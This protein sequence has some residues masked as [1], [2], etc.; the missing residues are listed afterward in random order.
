ML[1]AA[2]IGCGRMGAL[3]TE[4]TRKSVPSIWLPLS[5]T[6]A[7]ASLP[8]Y[9]LVAVC[10][11]A[12]EQAARV[13][14]KFPGSRPY[15]DHRLMLEKEKPAVVGIATRTAG[16]CDIIADCVRAGV[17]GVHA[18]KPLAGSL[19]ECRM[20]LSELE[21]KGVAFT[22][23]AVRRYMA[24]YRLAREVMLSGEIGQLR[25]VVIEHG[26]DMLMWGHPHSVDL[27][28]FYRPDAVA[29]G[30]RARLDIR[31]GAYSDGV[32]DDDPL[33][34][35]ACIDFSDGS[36]AVVTSGHGFNVR[37]FGETGS[38]TVVGDGSRVELRKKE[39]GR[40]YELTYQELAVGACSS[41]T[42]AAFLNIESALTNG[43]PTGISYIEVETA[44]RILFAMA[45]SELQGGGMVRPEE[46]PDDFRVTGRFGDLYA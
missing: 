29:I 21:R 18:E 22:Y 34:V 4:R 1:N 19:R 44:H 37:L 31:Q 13:A 23:G 25:Q 38:V 30:V 32:L 3:T 45:L 36:S 11:R 26:S 20:A 46:V 12:P 17:K 15:S 16:R 9:R 39:G 2:V 28:M 35:N 41:G 42:Q 24:P 5:H 10:D 43:C 7:L 40:P 8:G 27:A 33:L 14:E 6:E